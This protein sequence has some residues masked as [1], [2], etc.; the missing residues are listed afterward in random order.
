MAALTNISSVQSISKLKE[1]YCYSVEHILYHLENLTK[2]HEGHHIHF[3]EDDLTLDRNY[4]IELSA[5][6]DHNRL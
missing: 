3:K 5:D 1:S 6:L 4:F 2:N